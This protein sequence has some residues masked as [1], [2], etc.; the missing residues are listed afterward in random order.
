MRVTPELPYLEARGLVSVLH[1][2]MRCWSRRLVGRRSPRHFL[3]EVA[4]VGRGPALGD[5]S[6]VGIFMASGQRMGLAATTPPV[7]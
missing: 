1:L 2:G 7:G 6:T 4:P 5:G 3:G